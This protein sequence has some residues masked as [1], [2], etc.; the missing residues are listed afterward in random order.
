[1]SNPVQLDTDALKASIARALAEVGESDLKVIEEI[2]QLRETPG[3]TPENRRMYDEAVNALEKSRKQKTIPV[4]RRIAEAI[5]KLA[6][7][8]ELPL[9]VTDRPA[10][11]RARKRATP[12]ETK[13][14]TP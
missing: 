8:L 12:T 11:R 10:R 9:G 2:R 7:E 14:P 13:A 6:S 5:V 4:R 1:M 3:L